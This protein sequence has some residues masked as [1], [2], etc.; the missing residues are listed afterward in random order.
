MNTG[1]ILNRI[2]FGMTLAASAVPGVTL[3]PVAEIDALRSAPRDKQ[4]DG[5]IALLF[6]GEASPE[7]REILL[8]GENPLVA[9]FA[10][11]TV[12][13]PAMAATAAGRGGRGAARG[14]PPVRPA[15]AG[16]RGGAAARGAARP[17]ELKGLQQIV[18]LALGAPEFQHR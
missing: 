1:A 5:V 8:R 18:G 3:S 17:I 11:D 16:G 13:P 6:G 4:V 9:A 7:T 15:A 10:N 12:S 2:N 14:Q